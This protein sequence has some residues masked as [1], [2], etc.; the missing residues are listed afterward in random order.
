VEERTVGGAHLAHEAVHIMEERTVGGANLAHEAMHM[1]EERTVRGA[2]IG[3][4]SCNSI[5]QTMHPHHA[6]LI[7][8]NK[9]AYIYNNK[10]LSCNPIC[11]TMHPCTPCASLHTC[12]A[13]P[14]SCAKRASAAG[15]R[16]AVGGLPC[17]W[18]R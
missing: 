13:A 12:Q 6:A 4:P 2:H 9:A 8:L 7:R 5:C 10:T 14:P 16:T 15:A 17:D 1:M 3:T 18:Q 11:Q